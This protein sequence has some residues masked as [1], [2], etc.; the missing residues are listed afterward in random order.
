MTIKKLNSIIQIGGSTMQKNKKKL[1]IILLIGFL[2]ITL[3]I[4]FN[5]K[6]EKGKVSSDKKNIADVIEQDDKKNEEDETV[7]VD[8]QELNGTDAIIEQEDVKDSNNNSG[9][10]GSN[11]S[12]NSVSSNNSSN[13]K[14]TNISSNKSESSPKIDI[15][16]N[17]NSTNNNNSQ[18][19]TNNYDGKSIDTSHP[20]YSIHKGKKDC[21]DSSGCMDI[22]LPIQF[23]YKKNIS[24]TFYVEVRAKDGTV[25]GYFIE[26]VFKEYTYSSDEECNQIGNEIK[27]KL[28]DRVTSYSCNAGTLKINTNY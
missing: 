11:N 5:K 6:E 8:N 26:Y 20:D 3:F 18:A 17:N 16:T 14:S 25:L 27:S 21:T 9:E 10:N 23:K 24:N 2:F 1:I 13:S 7:V 4:V 12:S 15:Q 22:S 28:S 19:S